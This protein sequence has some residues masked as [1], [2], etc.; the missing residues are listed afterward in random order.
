MIRRPPRS[1]LFPY[2]T[3]FRSRRAVPR[4]GVGDRAQGRARRRTRP[5]AA[6]RRGDRAPPERLGGGGGGCAR[7]SADARC[8]GGVPG[9]GGKR[10]GGDL[11]GWAGPPPVVARR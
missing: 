7:G 5:D 2:T 11:A 10:G 3:L 8:G 1:T 9:V 4:R 6:R